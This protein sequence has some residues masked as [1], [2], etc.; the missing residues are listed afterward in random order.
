M[1]D[2]ARGPLG[3][4]PQDAAPSEQGSAWQSVEQWTR[5]IS[6]ISGVFSFFGRRP[7]FRAEGMDTEQVAPTDGADPNLPL[8]NAAEPPRPIGWP[9]GLALGVAIVV[10]AAVIAG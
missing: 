8:G 6:S 4:E 9:A 1:S 5:H 7:A 3:A 2:C 10:V